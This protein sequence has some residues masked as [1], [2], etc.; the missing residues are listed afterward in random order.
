MRVAAS[1]EFRGGARTRF[2]GFFL[3]RGLGMLGGLLRRCQQNAPKVL[4]LAVSRCL[5]P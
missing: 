1:S 3:R 5:A 4:S 2:G